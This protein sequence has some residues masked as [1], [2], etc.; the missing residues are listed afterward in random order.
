[1]NSTLGAPS[2]ARSGYGQAGSDWSSV[3]PIT[4]GKMVPDLYSFIDIST[5]SI[6][7]RYLWEIIPS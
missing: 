1:M 6:L 7:N 4:P 2:L 5:F 3:R